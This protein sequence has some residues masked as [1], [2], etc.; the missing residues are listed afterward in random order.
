M[1]LAI[2]NPCLKNNANCCARCSLSDSKVPAT[3]SLSLSISLPSLALSLSPLSRFSLHLF[4]SLSIPISRDC[5]LP[6]CLKR[7]KH[8]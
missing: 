1:H 4:L 8:N 2:F 3:L 7:F 6:V 5:A